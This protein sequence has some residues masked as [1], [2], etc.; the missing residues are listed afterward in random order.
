MIE[1]VEQVAEEEAE[2]EAA[3]TH[4]RGKPTQGV[5]IP[6]F[7]ASNT[8]FCFI[9]RNDSSPLYFLHLFP[10]RFAYKYLI[11]A[12]FCRLSWSYYAATLPGKAS[13]TAVA[14]F[15]ARIQ[16]IHARLC[17]DIFEIYFANSHW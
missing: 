14:S 2:E 16:S 10:T 3:G 11:S 1:Q 8:N 5:A 9:G 7:S 4:R 15:G 13:A 6:E 17:F 12:C